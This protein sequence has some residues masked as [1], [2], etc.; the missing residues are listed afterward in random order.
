LALSDGKLHLIRR[1]VHLQAEDP[2]E[3]MRQLLE[4]CPGEVDSSHAFYLGY[5][6]AKA[7]TAR[8]LGKVYRQ[9]EALRWGILTEEEQSHRG[10][11]HHG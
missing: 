7:V 9:D 5:E 2:F 1:D 10:P 6:L 4:Q 3:L 8:T 11:S